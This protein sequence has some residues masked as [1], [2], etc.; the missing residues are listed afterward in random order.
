MKKKIFIALA[1]L[2]FYYGI[3]ITSSF[4]LKEG[5]AQC[6][7]ITDTNNNSNPTINLSYD[8]IPEVGAVS[9]SMTYG[10]RLRTS[11]MSWRLQASRSGPTRTSG[12]GPASQNISASD[13]NYTASL[14]G[15][16]TMAGSATLVAPFN[17]VTT[18]SSIN[19][20]NT[21][22]VQ[23]TARTAANCNAMSGTYWQYSVTESIYPD[24]F[25][26]VGTYSDTV[27]YTLTAP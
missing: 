22:I 5:E 24:F 23:G 16:M 1:L 3:R 12:S 10:I 7:S 6:L 15:I 21:P 19:T 2:L 27:S 18:Q 17:A 20:T 13:I 4:G 9:V 26:N 14:V 8:L 11:A 25:Y